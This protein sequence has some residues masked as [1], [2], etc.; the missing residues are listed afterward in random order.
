MVG[1]HAHVQLLACLSMTLFA[2]IYAL[3]PL[4][5]GKELD[6]KLA[7]IHLI[8]FFTGSLIMGLAM[9]MAGTEGMLRRTLYSNGEFF[10]YM[11]I[12]IVGGLM[13]FAGYL[14][15]VYNILKT[16]GLKAIISLFK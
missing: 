12:A 7:N 4:L 16:Y 11:F 1:I 3:A 10:S 15:F 8:L 9:G 13:I 5:T 2:V 14:T 6:S